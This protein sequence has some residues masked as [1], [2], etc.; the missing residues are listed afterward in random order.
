[1]SRGTRDTNLASDREA[2]NTSNRKTLEH[3]H[4]DSLLLMQPER[5]PQ[6]SEGLRV[7]VRVKSQ[8]KEMMNMQT[9]KGFL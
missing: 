2:E 4:M 7:T 6:E 9:S 3:Q 1:M 5:N 8:R